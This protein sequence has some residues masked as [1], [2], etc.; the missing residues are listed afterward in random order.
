MVQRRGDDQRIEHWRGGTANPGKRL[1]H[2]VSDGDQH[3]ETRTRCRRQIRVLD[4]PI[5]R[6]GLQEYSGSPDRLAPNYYRLAV[7]A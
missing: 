6:A 1:P 3:R 5:A 7:I 2:R 4:F